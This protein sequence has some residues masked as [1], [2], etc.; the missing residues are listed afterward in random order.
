MSPDDRVQLFDE[1]PQKLYGNFCPL[2]VLEKVTAEL[3]GY[4]PETAGRLMTTEF[5]D[6]KEMQ[7]AA[8]AL[9]LVRKELNYRN[10]L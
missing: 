1:L 4:Q 2:L 6:L 5:I 10:N 3:L 9:S 8:E 7:T